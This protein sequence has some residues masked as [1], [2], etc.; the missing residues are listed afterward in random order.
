M[1][2]KIIAT[3]LIAI[4][5]MS[6]T[7]TS[8]S[9]GESPTAGA[10]KALTETL[11]N[12]RVIREYKA[13]TYYTTTRV[14]VRYEPSTD[15]EILTTLEFNTEIQACKWGYGNS[16]S[17]WYRIYIDGDAYYIHSDYLS[18][19]KMSYITYDVVSGISFKSYTDYRCITA[20]SSP[21]Y[22]L[23]H[24]YAYTGTYGIRMVNGRYCVALGSRFGCKIGQY[25][26]VVLENGTVI[27]CIMCDQKADAH[28]DSTN[29]Y[30]LSCKCATEFYI[31]SNSLS[32]SARQM[33]DVS[34]ACDEWNSDIT[35]IIVYEE[36]IRL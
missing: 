35:Q 24:S 11:I 27:Q 25:F 10:T 1:K 5:A 34:Y 18:T 20:T 9:A 30:S 8:V 4:T 17:E 7:I 23:Q 29:T 19:E 28:T 16:V 36:G 26:D 32:S 21:Q 3:L 13:K 15:S 33:G 2:S 14:N 12:S 31:D 22:K 6:A